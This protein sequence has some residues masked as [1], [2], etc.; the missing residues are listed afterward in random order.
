[1]LG[2]IIEE[3]LLKQQLE[4]ERL[5]NKNQTISRI[6]KEFINCDSFDFQ[7]YLRS[8]SIPLDF[9][10]DFLVQMALHKRTTLPI[11]VGILHHH[12]D[13]PQQTA[14]MIY[15]AVVADLANWNPTTEQLIVNFTL[16]DEIQEE[17]DR[18]Q[19][20]LPM[21]IK[22]RPVRT[23]KDTGYVLGSGSMILK[24]NHHD[25]DICLDHINRVNAV[26][27]TLDADTAV[28]IHNKWRNLD[29]PKEGESKAE[30][31]QR[32]KAFEKYDRTA[33]H[34]MKQISE[35]SEEFY[36]THKYDKRGRTYCQGYHINYQGAPWNKA[37][38]HLANKEIVE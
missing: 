7:E 18:Y 17:L 14:N 37:V 8:R 20:P 34:V 31:E 10:I 5:Y 9:G 30:F 15:K 28:M 13:D 25:E 26:R 32:K 4:L 29:K 35:I 21:V 23:N 19:Y 11:M 16:S 12:F 6:R 24:N 3:P 36:L 2:R 1:M 33:R 27:F 22:P 38:I